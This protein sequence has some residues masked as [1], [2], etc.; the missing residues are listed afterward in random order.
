MQQKQSRPA[1]GLVSRVD[2]M[3]GEAVDVMDDT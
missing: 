2:H 3:H 1:T